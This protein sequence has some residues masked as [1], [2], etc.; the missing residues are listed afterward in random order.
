MELLRRT[1][2][3]YDVFISHARR[4]AATYAAALAEKLT[5]KGFSCFLD[6]HDVRAGDE[7][8]A[9]LVRALRASRMLVLVG[10]PG[11]LQSRY[12]HLEVKTFAALGRRRRKLI[13]INIGNNLTDVAW[14]EI[15]GRVE[16]RELEAALASSEPSDFV[17]NPAS[18]LYTFADGALHATFSPDGSRIL[19][20]L[21]DREAVIRA[22]D[23]TGSPVVLAG[24]ED[25][26]ETVAF[27][28][29]GERA[30]TL[31]MTGTVRVWRVGWNLLR[32]YLRESTN[33]CLTPQQRIEL[34]RESRDRARSEFE[35]CE[36]R[37]G[38]ET[39][40]Q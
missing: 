16:I 34:Y 5:K 17:E 22:S 8:D 21:T 2:L 25:D 12:V 24:H 33:A 11:A 15:Q 31:A 20:A 40:S 4:D 30:L 18:P 35:S 1:L 27:S 26:V 28:P 37:H 38:R 3:G 10:S 9:T 23:G 39:L 7:L 29:D 36:R 32:Q 14:E 6:R 19:A 13:P